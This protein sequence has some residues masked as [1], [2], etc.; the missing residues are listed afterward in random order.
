M[1]Q[2]VWEMWFIASLLVFGSLFFVG[3]LP[4]SV[5]AFPN[6][7]WYFI[8]SVINLAICIYYGTKESTL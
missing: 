6:F 4:G 5:D 1:R 3:T 2:R 8:P 7:V